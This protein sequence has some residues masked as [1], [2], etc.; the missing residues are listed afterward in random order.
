MRKIDLDQVFKDG[1]KILNSNLNT[2][3]IS[4]IFEDIEVDKVYAL[5]PYARDNYTLQNIALRTD[6]DTVTVEL[7]I[8]GTKVSTVDELI[9]DATIEDFEMLSD[10]NVVPGDLVT[11]TIT[12]I[13]DN[14]TA[15]YA[16]LLIKR[17]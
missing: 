9:A 16:N 5:D 11:L 8:N 2:E 10:N 4:F 14:A 3:W 13:T 15:L 17:V 7:A 1:R 6:V 12:A